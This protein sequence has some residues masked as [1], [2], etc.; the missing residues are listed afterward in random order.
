MF[1]GCFC[2]NAEAITLGDTELHQDDEV[3]H[4]ETRR[5]QHMTELVNRCR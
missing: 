3:G 2:C 4:H 5:L 1:E